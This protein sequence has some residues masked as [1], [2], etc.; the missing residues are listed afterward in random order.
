MS[1]M[2]EQ[3][4][5]TLA[6]MGLQ[7][8]ESVVSCSHSYTD[9][10]R[11]SSWTGTGIAVPLVGMARL[12]VDGTWLNDGLRVT[13]DQSTLDPRQPRQGDLIDVSKG[14]GKATTYTIKD[15]LPDLVDATLT[16]T[17]EKRF[18]TP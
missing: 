3:I 5:A 12:M 6:A 8:P 15:A 10:G 18:S 16:L 7:V 4:A 2:A 17:L 1:A 9:G 13:I 11:R 14:D